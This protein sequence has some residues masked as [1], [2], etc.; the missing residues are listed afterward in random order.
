MLGYRIMTT[1]LE[2]QYSNFVGE[3]AR[4]LDEYQEAMKAYRVYGDKA[5][6]IAKEA[7]GGAEYKVL[8]YEG[9]ETAF[10]KYDQEKTF[11]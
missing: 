2:N 6:E 11:F 1:A 3:R 9:V 5:S 10:A 7:E 8:G 4:I